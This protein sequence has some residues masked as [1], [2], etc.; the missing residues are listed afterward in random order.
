MILWVS[1][2]L[3]SEQVSGTPNLSFS[4]ALL[5]VSPEQR[6]EM[7]ILDLRIPSHLLSDSNTD[8]SD[9]TDES[10]YAVEGLY[11][12]DVADNIFDGSTANPE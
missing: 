10:S 3:K 7:K 2:P 11:T 12:L 9:D 4:E 6:E 8:S 1:K 5:K